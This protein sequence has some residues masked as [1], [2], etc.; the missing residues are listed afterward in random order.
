MQIKDITIDD[1]RL[2]KNWK[3]LSPNTVNWGMVLL[4]ELFIVEIEKLGQQDVIVYSAVFVED[5]GKTKPVLMIKRVEDLN[6]GGD[7][8]ELVNGEWRQVGLV[9]NPNAA[10]GTEYIADPLEQDESFANDEDCRA[11]HRNG[12]KKFVTNL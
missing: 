3:V 10:F 8:C 4:E 5:G 11:Y 7:Y 9:P 12:F 6:Y 1:I 2:G